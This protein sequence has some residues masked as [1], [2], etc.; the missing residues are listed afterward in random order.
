M[1]DENYKAAIEVAASPEHV[2]NCIAKV[3]EWWSKDFEGRS[4]KLNDEF[5]IRH[6]GAHFS[7]QQL[8]EVI[9]SKKIVWL[10]TESRLDWLEK[11]MSEWTNTKMVFEIAER[12]DKTLLHFTHEG[13]VP[14]KECYERCRQDWGMVI[15][16]RLYNFISDNAG[17]QDI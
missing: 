7:K 2:F 12:E 8:V 17:T 15:K 16:E 5:T 4:E 14:G 6:P 9:P 10:V 13:L 3:P 11:D 1:Q